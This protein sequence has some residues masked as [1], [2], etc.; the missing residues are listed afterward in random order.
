MDRLVR[1]HVPVARTLKHEVRV[2][3]PRPAQRRLRSRSRVPRA[4]V[5]CPQL[6][7]RGARLAPARHDARSAAGAVRGP[8]AADD[9]LAQI[10]PRVREV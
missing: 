7:V 3:I 4:A 5:R 10:Y 6:G 9:A 2:T 8:Y 1:A